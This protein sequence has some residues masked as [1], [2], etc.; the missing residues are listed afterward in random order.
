VPASTVWPAAVSQRSADLVGASE[1]VRARVLGAF[2][3][4]VYLLVSDRVLPVV[5]SD[6]LRLPTSVVV[7]Q[8][9]RLVGWGVQPG[10]RVSVGRGEVR[11]PDVTLRGV[12]S[13]RPPRVPV[14]ARTPMVPTDFGVDGAWSA[15]ARTVV[16]TVLAGGDVDARV[17]VLIGAGVGLTP[18][19]DDVLCGILLGLRLRGSAAAAET[20]WR[21]TRPWLAATT[22]L[23]ASLLTE[24]SHGYAV[25]P[26]V[27]LA[28]ALAGADLA[29]VGRAV[30]EVLAIG[31]TSGADLL[32][33]FGAA[34]APKGTAAPVRPLTAL[35]GAR[36]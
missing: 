27:R 35:E 14:C 24:A 32:A 6:A 28:R 33:G 8:P 15:A 19:G 9:A 31:H 7:A 11:L 18:S 17:S 25:P 21:A 16:D 13:W 12:R 34:L 3:T 36:R 20:L 26:V 5:T 1:P 30:D 22:S 29:A 23:S 10:D 2:P 4:A